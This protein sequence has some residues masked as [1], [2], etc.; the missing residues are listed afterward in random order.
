[1]RILLTFSWHPTL[2]SIAFGENS[3]TASNVNILLTEVRI[4]WSVN[5]FVKNAIGKHWLWIRSNFSHSSKY[6]MLA[7]IAW[8]I[9]DIFPCNCFFVVACCFKICRKHPVL[10]LGGFLLLIFPASCL[11]KHRIVLKR[12]LEDTTWTLTKRLKKKL[13]SNYTRMLR[14]ILNKSWR[15]HTTRNQL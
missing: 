15:Q 9:G 4:F 7:L 1:M 14:A 12:S 10:R 13:D 11:S 3:M 8:D 6:I 5:T 2:A